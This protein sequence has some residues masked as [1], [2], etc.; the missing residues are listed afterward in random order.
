MCY[1]AVMNLGIDPMSPNVSNVF[2]EIY[3]WKKKVFSKWLKNKKKRKS[4]ARTAHRRRIEPASGAAA[5]AHSRL[6]RAHMW[7][8]LGASVAGAS[9]QLGATGAGF[10]GAHGWCSLRRRRGR[11]EH[12]GS[13]GERLGW[14]TMV[15]VL[16]FS[17]T[18]AP[19]SEE[20]CWS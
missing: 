7:V 3:L 4:V 12:E 18:A 5:T 2:S 6:E 17:R 1:L 16:G 19:R 8:W 11:G 13:G 14:L 15:G 9:T 20:S 10:Y